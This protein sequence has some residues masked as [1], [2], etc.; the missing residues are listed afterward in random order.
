MKAQ[1]GSHDWIYIHT[2]SAQDYVVTNGIELKEF[3]FA[4]F[5]RLNHLLLLKHQ[6]G[7]ASYNMHTYLE[8]V[9]SDEVKKMVRDD[10]VAYGDFCWID[11]EDEAG[12]DKGLP[13]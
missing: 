3:Y 4:L 5:D 10:V 9:K 6:Y 11:F 7:N 1:A 2:N 13:G 12:L 8:F